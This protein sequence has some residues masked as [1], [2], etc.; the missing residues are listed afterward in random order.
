MSKSHPD[1]LTQESW[2]SILDE[3]IFA[4]ENV[5]IYRAGSAEEPRIKKGL[6]LFAEYYNDLWF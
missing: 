2:N 4:F 6:K 1:N 5:P 3:M